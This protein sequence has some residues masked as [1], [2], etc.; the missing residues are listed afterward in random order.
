M[1]GR[2]GEIQ[3]RR[4]VELAN[5]A[6]PD[7]VFSDAVIKEFTKSAYD[8]ILLRLANQ[9][10]QN[11]R[12]E[13]IVLAIPANTIALTPTS[14]PPVPDMYA[15]IRLWERATGGTGWTDMRQATDHMPVNGIQVAS[16]GWWEWR[17][18]ALRFIGSTTP[19]DVKIHFIPRLGPGLQMPRD[20]FAFPDLVNPVAFLAASRM[21]GGNPY[22]ETCCDTD[23]YNIASIQTHVLQSKPVR[24]RRRRSGTRRY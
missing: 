13:A 2:W 10:L 18:N 20:Q 11:L 4:T 17:D 5:A 7:R 23:L 15:P 22:F 8:T 12:R 9:G 16:L 21:V 1:R 24:L 19:S 6:V 3:L 14:T